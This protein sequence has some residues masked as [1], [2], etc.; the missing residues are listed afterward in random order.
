M[1]DVDI[2]VKKSI[3]FVKRE[4]LDEAPRRTTVPRPFLVLYELEVDVEVV[5][6]PV[7]VLA[8]EE[9]D[10]AV[11][12]IYLSSR[13]FESFCGEGEKFCEK[14][15]IASKTIIQLQPHLTRAYLTIVLV[16]TKTNAA[17]SK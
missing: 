17:D 4:L 3:A 14:S 5:V 15:F 16:A 6:A 9:V 7:V 11:P 8:D 10:A 1:L 2:E 13:A 12:L